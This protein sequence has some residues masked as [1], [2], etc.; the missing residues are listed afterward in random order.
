MPAVGLKRKMPMSAVPMPESLFRSRH[1]APAPRVLLTLSLSLAL[2]L[3]ALALVALAMAWQGTLPQT[4]RLIADA[5]RLL[6][7][8]TGTGLVLTV[9]AGLAKGRWTVTAAL[10]LLVAPLVFLAA[11]EAQV[12]TLSALTGAEIHGAP[13]WAGAFMHGLAFALL[14]GLQPVLARQGAGALAYAC[15]GAALGS[16]AF[17]VGLLTLPLEADLLAR[18]VADLGVAIAVA[19]ALCLAHR[20]GPRAA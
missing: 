7:L 20:K 17:G 16:L 4:P 18:A 12:A 14:G 1:P 6:L 11:R 13:P 5:L 10:S 3:A 9:A 8:V 15:I 19:L 2:G